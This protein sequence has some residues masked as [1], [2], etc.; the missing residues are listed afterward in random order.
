MQKIEK[1]VNPGFEQMQQEPINKGKK[2]DSSTRK[3]G[4]NVSVEK[5]RKGETTIS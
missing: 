4:E 5:Y 2:G 3:K 1:I